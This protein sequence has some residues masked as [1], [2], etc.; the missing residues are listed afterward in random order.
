[1]PLIEVT[2]SSMSAFY[3]GPQGQPCFK[4]KQIFRRMRSTSI[5]C[6]VIKTHTRADTST[7]VPTNPE[8]LQISKHVQKGKED[9]MMEMCWKKRDLKDRKTYKRKKHIQKADMLNVPQ[10][11]RQY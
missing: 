7:K 5:N 1:M 10:V 9:M 3:N 11:A 2:A 4:N 6:A 8:P